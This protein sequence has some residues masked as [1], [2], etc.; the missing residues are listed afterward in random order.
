MKKILF[1]LVCAGTGLCT[2][3]QKPP[4]PPPA[5]P[6]VVGTIP[7]PPVVTVQDK[8]IHEFYKRNPSVT[9][10]SRQ[11]TVVTI[12]LKEKTKEKYDLARPSEASGFENKYGECPVP[13]PPPLA[14]C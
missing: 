9:N 3:A 7:P 13:P 11:G 8:Q 1:V 10:I 6:K 14:N 2:S 4:P 12:T 5:P